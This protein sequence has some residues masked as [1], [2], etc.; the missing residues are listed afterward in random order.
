MQNKLIIS[1]L[2]G[3]I[4]V[5]I[6]LVYLALTISPVRIKR[7]SFTYE[8]GDKISTDVSTYVN[9]NDSVLKSI[10]LDLSAVKKEVGT[11]Y[12]SFEYSGEKYPFEIEIVDTKKPKVE[13]KSVEFT[14]QLGKTIKAKDLIKK[15]E[16]Y[17]ETTVYFVD[18]KTSEKTKEKSYIVEGSYIERIIVE[19]AHGNQS[20][21]YRVKIVVE[22]NQVPPV[23]TGAEDITIQ[24]DQEFDV[25]K[26][27]K[28]KDDID[29]DITSHIKVDGKINNQLPG[30][31]Q[32]VYTVS[33][34]DGNIGKVVRKVTVE[35]IP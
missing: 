23:I 25:M 7:Q 27:V 10:K 12:A 19:D 32:I 29:G 8:Y 30:E 3:F 1:I 31:Y 13:L 9:A 35:Q 5:D 21:S 33:D 18:E 17:S 11:Y 4:L 15:V 26:G 2:S 22:R 6:A 34:T 16:D 14:I 24:I 28:A 20:A